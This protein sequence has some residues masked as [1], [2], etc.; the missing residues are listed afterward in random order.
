[1][2]MKDKFS[3]NKK[4]NNRLICRRVANTEVRVAPRKGIAGHDQQVAPRRFLRERLPARIPSRRVRK[5][6]ERPL[7]L[8]HLIPSFAQFPDIVANASVVF[9]L[10]GGAKPS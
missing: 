8:S 10:G 5:K 4:S 2:I 3:M 7:R 6:I 1:M 9:T